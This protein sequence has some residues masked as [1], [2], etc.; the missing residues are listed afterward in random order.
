MKIVITSHGDLC[1]GLVNSLNMIAGT[2]EHIYAVKLTESGIGD[3]TQKLYSLFDELLAEDLVLILTDIKGGT[4]Y[5]QSYRYYLQHPDK[6][7]VVYGVNLPML[8]ETSLMLNST[9]SL[10]EL[11]NIAEN[12]A[13]TGIGITEPSD[14]DEDDDLF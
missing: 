14:N 13:K 3:Y 9:K 8:I 11:A 5:N 4:P 6:T 7:K 1:T 12:A 2:N 10:E